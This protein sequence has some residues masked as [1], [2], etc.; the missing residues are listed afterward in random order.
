M[1]RN[2]VN[3]NNSDTSLDKAKKLLETISK[4]PKPTTTISTYLEAIP[5]SIL[6][7]E[8]AK[9]QKSSITKNFVDQ[10]L[11]SEFFASEKF[12]YSLTEKGLF[13]YQYNT[14]LLLTIYY[15]IITM[16]LNFFN[17]C[18]YNALSIK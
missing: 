7:L 3:S 9:T 5:A 15:Y 18:Y 14:I 8:T 17:Y 13:F 4:K 1:S 11:K 12:I 10:L 6:L 2:I 16:L